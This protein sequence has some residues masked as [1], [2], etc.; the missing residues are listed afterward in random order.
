M[1]SASINST[2]GQFYSGG[3]QTLTC[4]VLL[5]ELVDT[6]VNVS[7]LWYKSGVL[8]SNN[9]QI[10]V[11]DVSQISNYEYQSRITFSSVSMTLDSGQY[12]CEAF[13]SAY[14]GS[15]HIPDSPL[16]TT[17]YTL[18]TEGI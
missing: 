3:R 7:I 6:L 15:P 10:S 5:N 9:S 8:I 4:R 18:T 1:P 2:E 11:S 16:V 13:V 14:P 17:L 12:S